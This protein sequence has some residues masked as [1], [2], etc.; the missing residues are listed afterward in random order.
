MTIGEDL[1]D[2]GVIV[3]TTVS[4]GYDTDAAGSGAQRRPVAGFALI[5]RW[6]SQDSPCWSWETGSQMHGPEGRLMPPAYTSSIVP[7]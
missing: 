1:L 6:R 4:T 3:W 2:D 7:L 5:G